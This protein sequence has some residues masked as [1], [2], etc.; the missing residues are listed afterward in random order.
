M[1]PFFYLY[2]IVLKNHK[3]AYRA[4][5]QVWAKVVCFLIGI[6]PKIINKDKLPS[7]QSYVMI[8]NH[9]SQL[10]IVIPLTLI[11][12]SFAFLS[13]EELAKVPMF[14]IHFKGVHLTV[15]RKDIVSGVGALAACVDT[16]KK[17]ISVLI[18]PEGT[19]SRKAPNMRSFKKGPFKIALDAGVPIVPVVFLDN[20][21]RLGEGS[22]LKAKCGPG[23]ARM[24]VLDP[25]STEGKTAKDLQELLD[26]SYLQI[27]NC[28]KEYEIV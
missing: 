6:F 21:K 19:R 2:I 10:D 3:L 20:Y 1:Y 5:Y 4:G 8:S 14:G 27:E 9:T 16:L 18:F 11:K 28:L 24:V 25:I 22:L 23:R 15:N 17:D 26:Y 12:R 7:D 13:K